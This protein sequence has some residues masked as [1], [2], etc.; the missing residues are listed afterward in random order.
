MPNLEP[1]QCGPISSPKSMQLSLI[2]I[3]RL[4]GSRDVRDR[5][6]S[7]HSKSHSSRDTTRNLSYKAR[8]FYHNNEGGSDKHL[9]HHQQQLGDRLY[10]RV[11][12]IRPNMACKIT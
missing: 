7:S 4:R 10:P 3:Q 6:R 5:S 9:A 11:Q 12:Q 1:A 8:P 2:L